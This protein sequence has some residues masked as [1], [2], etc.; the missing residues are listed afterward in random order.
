MTPQEMIPLLNIDIDSP[1]WDGDT[2]EIR[3]TVIANRQPVR[4]R[5]LDVYTYWGRQKVTVQALRGEPFPHT[6]MW[7]HTWYSDTCNTHL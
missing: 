1:P 4:V 5:V 3:A 2:K 6:N 7:Y